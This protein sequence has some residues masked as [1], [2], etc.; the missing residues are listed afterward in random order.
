LP[1]TVF[2]TLAKHERVNNRSAQVHFT[3]PREAKHINIF[4]V[5]IHIDVVEDLLFYHYPREDLIADD[6][7]PWREFN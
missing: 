7:V 4:K 2:L 1:H 6:K 5:I 3:R